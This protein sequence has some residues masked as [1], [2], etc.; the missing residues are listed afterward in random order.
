M[1]EMRYF[2]FISRFKCYGLKLL[3]P[4]IVVLWFE[5]FFSKISEVLYTFSRQRTENSS[6]CFV[7]G[8]LCMIDACDRGCTFVAIFLP[9]HRKERLYRTPRLFLI[10]QFFLKMRHTGPNL[11]R[12]RSCRNNQIIFLLHARQN[13]V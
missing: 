8:K 11:G 6:F 3:L 10:I 5:L 2:C 4:E 7:L 9:H 1:I 12:T 13:H